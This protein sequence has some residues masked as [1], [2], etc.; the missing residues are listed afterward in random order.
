MILEAQ[1]IRKNRCRARALLVVLLL[2]TAGCSQGPD[3]SVSPKGTSP[4]AELRAI[5]DKAVAYPG[6]VI[7]FTLETESLPDVTVELPE[8][9]SRFSEFRLIGDGSSAPEEKGGRVLAKRWYKL[10]ADTAGSY[11][12][13]PIEA[14]YSMPDGTREVLKTPKIFLEIVSLLAEEGEI[15]DIRDIKPPMDISNRYQ[16][17]L[18]IVA[19]LLAVV[20]TILIG[21]WAFKRWRRRALEQSLASR[22]PHEVAL[23]ALQQLLAK[24]LIESGRQREFCFEVSEIF[25]RYMQARFGFP[26][27][28]LTTE[29]ILPCVEDN[30][31]VKD[32]LKPLVREFLTSTDLVKFARYLPTRDELDRIIEDT[33]T[34]IHETTLEPV[35]EVQSTEGGETA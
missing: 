3:A 10:Q 19:V 27:I 20:L 35:A 29:E 4:P 16:V 11:I 30:G 17:T 21:R 28:D 9:S 34:F 25:R 24:K 8:I 14:A 26:A 6:D 1:N 32:T 13:D 33:R 5:I 18:I 31:I 15:N 2:A 12:I 7:T 22:P 23:E